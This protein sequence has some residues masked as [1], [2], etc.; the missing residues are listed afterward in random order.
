MIF[1]ENSSLLGIYE[2][3][4]KMGAL[5]VYGACNGVEGAL[6]GNFVDLDEVFSK[7]NSEI[8]MQTPACFLGS[9][10]KRLP[11]VVT[12]ENEL[13]EL[14]FDE[15]LVYKN[16]AML[17]ERLN[18]SA[19]F[20]IG[21]NDSME[22]VWKLSSFF[23]NYDGFSGVKFLGV[24]KTIDNDLAKTDHC[25]GFGSAA[26]FVATTF[27]E[28]DRDLSV[29]LK[30]SV[31][32]VEVMGRDAGWLTAASALS[33]LNGAKGPDLIY[34]CESKF[35]LNNFLTAV[36]QGLVKN[37]NGRVFV[38]VSEGLHLKNRLSQNNLNFKDDF[39]HICNLGVAR[40]L[41][42]SVFKHLGCK[43]RSF[44]LSLLQRSSAHLVSKV[45]VLEAKEVGKAAVN[46]AYAGKTGV[47]V[48][49]KRISTKPYLVEF[50]CVDVSEVA[51]KVKKMPV[52]FLLGDSDVSNEAIEWLTPLIQGQ[53]S[54]VFENG[55]P[56]HLILN[57]Y[58]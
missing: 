31:T 11:G 39:E 57:H 28:L 6:A 21:G 47:M 25:P 32:I 1:Y 55:L 34:C 24:P 51:G 15:V 14:K 18:I 8:L 10:R 44:E 9:C 45:D 38:A 58:E 4:K 16:L 22:T 52:S 12:D 41:E 50:S 5:K 29:Y 46:F 40:N 26:K 27:L 13:S 43:V 23:S 42:L 3:S 20:Y 19:F 48:T 2:Q 53:L 7:V 30:P 54:T 36:E 35:S 56:K 49:I 33:R 17:F 37:K